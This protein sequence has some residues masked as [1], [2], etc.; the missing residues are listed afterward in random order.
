MADEQKPKDEEPVIRDKRRIDPETGEVRQPAAGS[1]GPAGTPAQVGSPTEAEGPDVETSPSDLIDEELARLLDGSASGESEL[2]AERLQDLKRLQA[3]YANYRKRVDRD[4]DLAR[5]RAIAETVLAFLPALD[6]LALAEA[7]GDLAEG[8]M[9]AVAQKLRAGFD[10]FGVVAVGEK[11]EPFDP[12]V[13]EAFLQQPSND[14]TVTT[15]TDVFQSGYRLGDRLIR[16][17][18]VAVAVPAETPTETPTETQ[19]G[20]DDQDESVE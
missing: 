7:H 16:P 20:S 5:E 15:V 1:S 18:K 12:S 3:E 2:A 19:A 10:R 9:L 11:G 17:A 14:V 6:D 8:P 4:R 13:H